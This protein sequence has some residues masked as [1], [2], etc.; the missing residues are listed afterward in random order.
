LFEDEDQHHD[1]VPN[2]RRGGRADR[3]HAARE[4]GGGGPSS[5]KATAPVASGSQAASGE[6]PVVS[7]QRPISRFASAKSCAFL[8]VPFHRDYEVVVIALVSGLTCFGVTPRLVT[9][10]PESRFRLAKLKRLIRACK[11]SFHDLS[12]VARD[13]SRR[14]PRFNMPFE[15]GLAVGLADRSH[16]WYVLEKKRHRLQASL[17]DLNG[18]DP[19]VHL[20]TAKGVRSALLKAFS[21][22]SD[23]PSPTLLDKVYRRVNSLYADLKRQYGTIFE[24]PVCFRQMVYAAPMIRA[25]ELRAL[26]QGGKNSR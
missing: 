1:A 16:R 9:E 18:V 3:D 11:Y 6:R 10:I 2:A 4:S 21:R 26:R 14:V 7:Q 22:R 12:Y 15:C 13:G 5:S 25:E 8:N 24:S 19:L 20:G 23:P 17:S